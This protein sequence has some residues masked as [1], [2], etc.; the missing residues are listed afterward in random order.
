ME[1]GDD[2]LDRGGN[3]GGGE[4]WLD[5]EYSSEVELPGFSDMVCEC[6]RSYGSTKIFGLSYWDAK[7]FSEG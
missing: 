1:C 5:P 3:S 6:E 4:K 2:G 7:L